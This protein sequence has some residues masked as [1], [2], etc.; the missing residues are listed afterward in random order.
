MTRLTDTP[1]NETYPIALN[2]DSLVAYIS[3]QS[4]INNTYLLRL[5]DQITIPITNI[6]TGIGQLTSN[7]QKDMIFFSGFQDSKYNL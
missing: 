3:D 6:I 7:G 2:N 5:H 4:G 1:H